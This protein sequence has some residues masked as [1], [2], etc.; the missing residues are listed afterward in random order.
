MTFNKTHKIIILLFIV[1]PILLSN[2]S[3]NINSNPILTDT[4]N[5]NDNQI[6]KI[7]TYLKPGDIV[8]CDVKPKINEYLNKIGLWSIG[9]YGFSNDHCA[10]YI[11][12]NYFIEAFPYRIRPLRMNIFGVT[13]SPFWKIKLWGTNFTY[14]YVKTDQQTRNE[15]VKWTLLRLGNPYQFFGSANPDIN[16]PND[17]FSNRWFCSELIWAAY[18]NQNVKIIVGDEF[19]TYNATYPGSL[20]IADNVVLYDNKPPKAD[21]G[22]P[23]SGYTNETIYFESYN[24]NGTN[25]SGITV[26]HE[27]TTKGIKKVTLTVIDNGDLEDIN[28]TTAII[29]KVNRPPENP[30]IEGPYSAYVDE[31]CNFTI[32]SSD[33][34][35]DKIKYIIDWGDYSNNSNNYSNNPVYNI[36]HKWNKSGYY[37]IDIEVRDYNSS[38]ISYKTIRIRDK[39]NPIDDRYNYIPM[40]ILVLIL[41]FII[42]VYFKKYLLK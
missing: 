37:T 8:F 36:S 15:A 23:Y 7:P 5:I 34:D 25:D 20:R 28:E 39:N 21:A 29:Q 12:K 1:S 31:I 35:Y 18:W 24:S 40:I 11:G 42:F 9:N 2:I 19:Y 4:E 13:I 26:D 6:N 3:E 32:T 17:V 22:G 38:S 33:P 14:A 16:D 41:V 30:I 27:Y 10:L